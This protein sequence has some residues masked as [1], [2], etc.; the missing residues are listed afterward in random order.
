MNNLVNHICKTVLKEKKNKIYVI[1]IDGP[2]AAGKTIL[3]GKIE[4]KL[5]NI[6]C[7]T[8]RMDWTLKSRNFRENSLKNY[9]LDNKEFL[10]EAEDHMNLEIV[11]TVL[12]KIDKFNMIHVIY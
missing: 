11:S 1:G 7:F 12:Q 8:I 6:K 3:A 10:Y 4:K 9:N 2:T 5:K